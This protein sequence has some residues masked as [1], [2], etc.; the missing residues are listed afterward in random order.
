MSEEEDYYD[1]LY[2]DES[3]YPEEEIILCC[4]CS[5]IIGDEVGYGYELVPGEH[6]CDMCSGDYDDDESEEI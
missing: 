1:H 6:V 2:N 4:M 3:E 5:H